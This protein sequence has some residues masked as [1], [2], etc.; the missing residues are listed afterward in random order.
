MTIIHIKPF[1]CANYVHAASRRIGDKG[2]HNK[3]PQD[4]MPSV[5]NIIGTKRPRMTN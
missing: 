3:T 2:P 5:K 4:K 1:C